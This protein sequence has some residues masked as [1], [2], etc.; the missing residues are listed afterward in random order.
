MLKTIPR[1]LAVLKLLGL[2]GLYGT[3][4]KKGVI[5]LL[6][7]LRFETDLFTGTMATTE[8]IVD[9]LIGSTGVQRKI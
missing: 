1:P 6:R 7:V 3:V 4:F 5:L 9:A 8:E 2:G